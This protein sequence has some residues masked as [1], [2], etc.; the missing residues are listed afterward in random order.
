MHSVFHAALS[1]A[2]TIGLTAAATPAYATAALAGPRHDL[3]ARLDGK[4]TGK[5]T[6]STSFQPEYFT[7]IWN[8]EPN[9]GLIGTIMPSGRPH[10]AVH[11]V[12]SSDTA[13]IYESTPH[14]NRMLHEEVVNRG[15]VHF[16]GKE[17][18]GNFEVRPTKY[19]GKSLKG[20]ISAA[21]KS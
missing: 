18:E 10:Y 3:A 7:M 20:T 12:W 9:G 4:W 13:F 16:R 6:S 2:A 14:Y 19:E 8:S 5:L 15:V 1:V 21:R 17:L 11:V